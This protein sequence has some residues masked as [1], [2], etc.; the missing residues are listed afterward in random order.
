MTALAKK[1][2]CM[3]SKF[4]ASRC[5]I[6]YAWGAGI[7]SPTRPSYRLCR[8]LRAQVYVFLCFVCVWRVYM[9][10]RVLVCS[11]VFVSV[12]LYCGLDVGWPMCPFVLRVVVI[13]D[14]FEAFMS[15]KECWFITMVRLYGGKLWGCISPCV[16]CVATKS[17]SWFSTPEMWLLVSR[18]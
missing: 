8:T 10:V 3:K 2:K 14:T 1:N 4:F 16:A 13:T 15:K 18:D 12:I 17:N 11:C 5:N 6:L 9:C 7:P